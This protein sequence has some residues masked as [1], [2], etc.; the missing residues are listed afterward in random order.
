MRGLSISTDAGVFD[1]MVAG[2]PGG[3]PVLLL[4]GFPQ[5]GLAWRRQIAALAAY[6]YRVV[7]PDQR[8]YS[9]GARPRRAE[10]YRMNLLVDDV[11]AITEELG[12][13]AFDLVGHDWG[14]AVAW[15]TAYAHPGRVRTLTVV[16]TPHPGALAT[17]LRGD[18][19]QRERSRYMRDWRET[20]AT[21]ERM[22]AHDAQE[23]RALYA[24]KVPRDSAEA[25]LRH[26]SR[27]GALTAALNWYRAGR[28]DHAIGAVEV[29]TLY[30]WS[31]QD[32]AFGPAAARETARWVDGPY[33][34]ETLQGVSHW[35]PEEAP[36]AL[37][38]LL[39]HHLRAHGAHQTATDTPTADSPKR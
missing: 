29:P 35:V 14:G 21:E 13:P 28:P 11:V 9:P 22:L 32:S 7:A 37:S 12:W 30:V 15:W 18:E 38:R 6:G 31:T 19:D 10:D 23:L 36:E 3:R 2:P 25:Y 26:L 17:A 24:G 5:T 33:R 1:A 20:P 4:H 8:G 27:P 16:S 34:F 39:L